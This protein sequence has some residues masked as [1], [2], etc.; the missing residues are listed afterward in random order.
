MPAQSKD[1]LVKVAAFNIAYWASSAT[2]SQRKAFRP[3]PGET[4]HMVDTRQRVIALIQNVSP[5]HVLK[6]KDFSTL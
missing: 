1:R 4:F 3:M 6:R 5:S 2:R